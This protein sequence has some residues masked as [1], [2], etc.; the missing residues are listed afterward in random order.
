MRDKLISLF[1][2]ESG[3]ESMI[4][5]LLAQSVFLGIF[6]GTFDVIAHSLFLS[7]FD[8]KI[9]A[10]GYIVS[11][12]TG[13]TLMSLYAWLQTRIRF[14]NLAIINLIV[15]ALF[16]LGLWIL[17]I[18]FPAKRVVFLVFIMLG[19]LNILAMLGFRG[20]TGRLFI[21]GPGKRQS[22]LLDAGLFTGIIISCYSIPAL[23]SF[24]LESHNILLVSALSVLI[25][26]VI[27][28]CVGSRFQLD[29]VNEEQK[30]EYQKA[31]R[32][33]VRVLQKDPYARNLVIY[34]ALSVVTA[35]FVQYSFMAVTREKYPSV[36]E[37]A[38]FLGVF[39]GSMMLFALLVRLFAYP[40][41]VRKFGFCTCLTISPILI[42]VFTALAVLVGML[43]GYTHESTSGFLIFFLVLAL[44][45]L[46]SRSL[47]ESIEFTSLKT[48]YHDFNEK[49][50]YKF[51]SGIDV[52]VNEIAVI[53][54]GLILTGYGVLCFIKLIHFSFFL[55]FIILVWVSV[56]FKLYSEYRKSIIKTLKEGDSQ[57]SVAEVFPGQS[58]LEG[59]FY[60]ET[61]FRSD[62]FKLISGDYSVLD[63]AKSRLYFQRIIDYCRFKND[64]NL[65]PV[66]KKIASKNNI[67]DQIRRQS[68]D[69][70]RDFDKKFFSGG[71]EGAK[72]IYSNK[73]L[74][75][76]RLPQ[77]TEILRLLRDSSIESKRSGL[78]MIGKF[79]LCDML[80]EVCECLNITG[81]GSDAFSVIRTFG[82]SA[83]EYLEK[84]YL[85]SSG[86]IYTSKTILRLLGEI[87]TQESMA[88]LFSRL[89]SNSRVLKEVAAKCLVNCKF[90]SSK[91]DRGRL[92]QLIS[93]VAGLMTWNLSAKICLK[94][95]NDTFLLGILEKEIKRWDQ[96]LFNL[97]SITY[98]SSAIDKIRRNLGNGTEESVNYAL[99]MIDIVADD[100][101][102]P[103]LISLLD[104]VPDEIKL[105]N[106]YHFFSGEIPAYNKI[107]EDIVNR[108]YNIL[109]LWTKACT[110]RSLNEIESDQMAESVVALLFSPER[111]IQEEA[112]KLI[113]RSGRELY[114]T[115]SGRIP[116]MAH[117]R[118]DK[119]INGETDQNE[120]LFE[121]V[122]FL[123][124]S[125]NG[126]PEEDLLTLAGAIK[127]EKDLHQGACPVPGGC[128]IWF[129]SAE[130]TVTGIYLVYDEK[131]GKTGEGF[132]GRDENTCYILPLNAV[133]EFI[134]QYPDHSFEILKCIN[135]YEESS[136]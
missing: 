92:N 110:L 131:V 128:I 9:M 11:G 95:N 133:A 35:F 25:A 8:E 7:I 10:R 74:S 90:L 122:R 41:I 43:K 125:F 20:T 75:E 105:K 115:A 36:E 123:S 103:K 73:V 30:T 12:L 65:V 27:Q 93:E 29:E 87:G 88:F 132:Q 19:P 37:M 135:S 2:I 47:K 114:M 72:V 100:S 117:K 120:L 63:G 96:F 107:H 42:L 15:V 69:V 119:I 56:A 85:A 134:F 83:E 102:K 33:V 22:G 34:I 59:R 89:W 40:Y 48:I 5:M 61:A 67:D 109:G 58:I 106:L 13:I 77:T 111:I 129:F 71:Q 49:I 53:L 91:G 94:K 136:G 51:Q 66:L 18:L 116:D 81:L 45:R 60:A 113:V 127:Y 64:V 57:K 44:S 76:T 104:N 98:G 24:G 78:F 50:K 70:A 28:I 82:S 38:R 97:L 26:A 99:E 112:A 80:P 46:F 118:L 32:S 21:F 3:E 39:T 16:T 1:G 6:F 130:K 23:L 101:L 84:F 31:K 55:F 108:D 62:Y 86:N 14:N 17:L 126:I 54:S 68:A 79:K 124:F 52:T 4:S 121:K